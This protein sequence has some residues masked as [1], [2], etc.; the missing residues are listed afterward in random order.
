MTQ[1]KLGRYDLIRVLGKGAMGLVYEGRDP[2]L[3]RRVAIKTIKVENLSREAAAEYEARFRTEARSAA[4]LQHPNI[5]SVYDSD[6]DGDIAFLVMEFIQGEDLKHH[7]DQGKRHSLEETLA[8][9]R[10][11]LSALEY[12][13]KAKIVHRDIKPANLLIE[14]DGRVKLTDFGVARIQDSGDAT[15][16]QGSMV[17]TLKYMSPEQVQGLPVDARSD[18]FAAGVVLYQMLTGKRPFDGDSDF[19]I[20]QRIVAQD[21]VPASSINPALPPAIDAVLARALAK[22]R[23]KRYATAQEFNTALQACAGMA[24]DAT[25]IPP[26]TAPAAGKTATWTGTVRAG[27]SLVDT[28]LGTGTGM[29]GSAVT[30]ELELVYWKEI[31]DSTDIE[32]VHG[33]LAR[34]PSG[35]YADL[36]R[37]RL[38]KLG[39]LTGEDSSSGSRSGTGAGTSMS[40][41]SVATPGPDKADSAWD[42]L[43]GAAEPTLVAPALQGPAPVPTETAPPIAQP[44][45][46]E[47]PVSP[48]KFESGSTPEPQSPAVAAPS[49]RR[50]V[51]ILASVVALAA[52][53]LGF[54]FL[55]GSAA[56]VEP[57][58][59]LAASA[60]GPAT[61][62]ASLAAAAP[63]SASVLASAP[64]SA[65]VPAA[66]TVALKPAAS[67]ASIPV[68]S[69]SAVAAAL[70]RKAAGDKDRL[71]KQSAAKTPGPA[72]ESANTGPAA[73]APQSGQSAQTAHPEP[74]PAPVAAASPRQ[75]CE[76][77]NF[78]SF[79]SCMSEQCA[80][81]VFTNHALCVERRMM[82]QRRRETEQQ[83][84]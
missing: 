28:Q 21:A 10:D 56:P 75:A 12:A 46:S 44:E 29:G 33:F 79:Q 82:E 58:P 57:T 71:S 41:G 32:D 14:A 47:S 43:T 55:S 2:N 40:A 62:G 1:N 3:D 72:S 26:V 81:P 83:R 31:K 54:K 19:A 5:V 64:A 4:R 84:R 23:D 68:A 22:S 61:A 13:H 67:T 80:K 25:A 65:P 70:A 63:A 59:A 34:F 73:H 18:L 17:G 77:R 42:A 51:W 36:A 7:L 9:M 74:A 24:T 15:R 69:A 20:I 30:Q 53:G 8:V 6:R 76:D 48:G 60:P 50:V 38:R 49:S 27:E 52:A 37:R 16:T 39:S 35:I 66:Q 78:I 11:L 45:P